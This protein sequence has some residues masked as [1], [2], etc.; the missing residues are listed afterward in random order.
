MNGYSEDLAFIHDA[1]FSGFSRDAAPGL[2]AL[3]RREG[4]GSGHVLDLGCGGGVWAKRLLDEGYS[5]QGIDIS[6][7]MI[8]LARR[9]A[10]RAKFVRA[11][12][13]DMKLPT[14]DAVT[15]LGECINY[16]F[17]GRGR[18]DDLVRLFRRVHGALRP[19][20]IF[21]FDF[22]E[23]GRGGGETTRRGFRQADDWA[24]LLEV[25][26][27]AARARLTRRMTLF[28][29]VGRAWRRT[30][31]T[32]HLRLYPRAVVAAALREAGFIARHLRG[33]GRLL[34]GGGHT[35]ILARR[36]DPKK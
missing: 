18:R 29:R 9:R 10:P 21:L 30:E 34:L 7:P 26:E 36:R 1:G 2:L 19:G 3:L 12:F 15:A 24:I 27:D 32:H 8:A 5:V 35:A 4:V 23:P 31:Q 6:A 16:L 13:H 25:E 11:S 20:G 22:A 17:H 28:R 33:Y 14:C